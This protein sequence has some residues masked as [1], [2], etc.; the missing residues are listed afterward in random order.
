V[1]SAERSDEQIHSDRAAFLF[2]NLLAKTNQNETLA[3][4]EILN[5]FAIQTD[6]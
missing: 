6:E 1:N 3:F 2:F 4:H 5:V